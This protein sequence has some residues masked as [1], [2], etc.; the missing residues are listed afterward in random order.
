VR[1]DVEELAGYPIHELIVSPMHTSIIP[2]ANQPHPGLLKDMGT[3]QT[4]LLL[5]VE[6][7]GEDP[8]KVHATFRDAALTD[9]FDIDLTR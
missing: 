1:H 5:D 6:R 4:F 8:V 9:H 3:P 2:A 7:K